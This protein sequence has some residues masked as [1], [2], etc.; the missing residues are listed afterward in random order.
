MGEAHFVDE[1]GEPFIGPLTEIETRV[2]ANPALMARIDQ[3][4]AELDAGRGIED[5][6]RPGLVWA[7]SAL[8]GM[9]GR[10]EALWDGRRS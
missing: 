5:P 4:L 10:E 3:A 9:P 8:L 7:P 6:G 2:L 1:D